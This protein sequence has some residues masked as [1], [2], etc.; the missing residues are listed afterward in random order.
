MEGETQDE[1]TLRRI[2]ALLVSLAT[3]AESAASRSF[4]VRWFVLAILRY[5]ERV[6]RGYVIESAP[7]AWPELD[8][9]LDVGNGPADAALLGQWFRMLAAVLGALLPPEDNPRDP[10]AALARVP[11][12]LEA[13]ARR[14][15]IL[16]HGRRLAFH[17]T[18]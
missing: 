3:M 10:N 8:D 4:P 11:R 6:A 13:R 9:D 7:W 17:D 1:R 2:I 5:A 18:S 12:F 15:A 14:R 16:P